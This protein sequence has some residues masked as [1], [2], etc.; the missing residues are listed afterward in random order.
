MSFY[1][2][3][4]PLRDYADAGLPLEV[5]S[6]RLAHCWVRMPLYS[7]ES[8]EVSHHSLTGTISVHYSALSGPTLASGQLATTILCF[9]QYS[10]PW[11]NPGVGRAGTPV[12]LGPGS[13]VGE[14]RT[15]GPRQGIP[16]RHGASAGGSGVG[17]QHCMGITLP[18]ELL[19]CLLFSLS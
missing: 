5:S 10:R 12:C 13:M 18:E 15:D 9:C 17:K 3:S 14:P 7:S 11:E 8:K 6:P 16:T 4:G 2:M 19:S 1:P